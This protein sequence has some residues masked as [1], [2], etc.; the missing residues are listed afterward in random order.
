MSFK[1]LFQP[2]S[3]TVPLALLVYWIPAHPY[4]GTAH[5]ASNL[6]SELDTLKILVVMF[7]EP[8]SDFFST[9]KLPYCGDP[10]VGQYCG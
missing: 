10:S 2:L 3:Y 7:F 8:F 5:Q 6:T 9:V 4:N 1:V